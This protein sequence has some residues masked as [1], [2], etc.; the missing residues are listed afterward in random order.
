MLA[1]TGSYVCLLTVV[2]WKCMAWLI[3]ATQAKEQRKIA[4]TIASLIVCELIF[5]YYYLVTKDHM[6]V[7]TWSYVLNQK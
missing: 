7:V 5:S 3:L 6:V 2:V 1:Y 4:W